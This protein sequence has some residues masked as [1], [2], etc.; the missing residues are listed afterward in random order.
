MGIEVMVA[1]AGTV[2]PGDMAIASH[3]KINQAGMTAEVLRALL[4]HAKVV[5]DDVVSVS[6]HNPSIA[7]GIHV[8]QGLLKVLGM[9]A[10][11]ARGQ[12]GD[13]WQLV[14]SASIELFPGDRVYG[15]LRHKIPGTVLQNTFSS[16][17]QIDRVA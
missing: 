16:Y 3:A 17:L 5:A 4:V 2:K 11:R 9:S 8:R 15:V 12:S 1:P 10:Q 13:A 7:E 6:L 14:H